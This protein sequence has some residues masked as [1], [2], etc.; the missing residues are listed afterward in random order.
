[1]LEKF[2][3]WLLRRITKNRQAILLSPFQCRLAQISEQNG[4]PVVTNWD[5]V[6]IIDSKGKLYLLKGKGTGNKI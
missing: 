6:F 2:C 1:M 3:N 5:N 4:T